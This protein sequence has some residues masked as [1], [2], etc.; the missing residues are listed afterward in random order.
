MTPSLKLR[1]ER[2]YKNKDGEDSEFDASTAARH[3]W[4]NGIVPYTF[5]SR[6]TQS[7]LSQIFVNA[8]ILSG[9][10]CSKTCLEQKY[11]CEGTF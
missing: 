4:T 6:F 3:K 9:I 1:L 5:H 11:F 10:L 2:M 7:K 8:V